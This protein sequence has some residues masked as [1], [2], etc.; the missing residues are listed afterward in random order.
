MTEPEDKRDRERQPVLR[1]AKLHF[2]SSVVDC[3]VLDLSADGVRIETNDLMALPEDVIIE[4]RSGGR[5]LA[6]RRWQ[7]GLEAGFELVRF[8][9]LEREAALRASVLYGM[10]RSCGL[11]DVLDRLAAAQHYDN[12]ELRSAAAAILVS[13]EQLETALKASLQSE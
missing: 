7:R 13:L 1:S 3:L 10:L 5:W 2:H 9:G 4:L 6:R 8:A 11:Q 12:P